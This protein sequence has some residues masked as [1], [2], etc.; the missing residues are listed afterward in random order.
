MKFTAHEEYGLRILLRIAYSNSTNGM[1]IP[2]ISQLEGLSQANTAKILRVLRIG[3]FID[4]ARGQSGGYKLTRLPEMIR[5]SDVLEKLGGKLF[6]TSFCSDFRGQKTICTNS[7]NC[8][9]RSVWR[10]VQTSVDSVLDKLTLRELMT[11]EASANILFEQINNT[12]NLS[13]QSGTSSL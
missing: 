12:E 1:T 2:E 10:A 9:I 13:L 6:E 7:I 11:D 8:S 4:S 3:G 5:I